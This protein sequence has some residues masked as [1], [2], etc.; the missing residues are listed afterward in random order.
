MIRIAVAA[1]LAAGLAGHALAQDR[2]PA[3]E[4]AEVYFIGLEDGM[5]VS[6]PV[7]VRFGARGI[8]IAP[9]GVDREGTGHHHLIVNEAIEGD[10]LDYAIPSDDNHLHFGGGQTEARVELPPGTHTLQLVMG[11]MNH[12]PHDPPIAS[13]PITV[14]V[15]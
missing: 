7:L 5:T 8:G 4:G 13:A 2:T 15:E 12:V 11:D 1:T 10:E 9:A 3:P 6:S 14:T